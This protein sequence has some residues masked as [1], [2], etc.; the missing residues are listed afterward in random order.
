MSQRVPNCPKRL[1]CASSAQARKNTCKPSRNGVSPNSLSPVRRRARS[2][3][4]SACD[5]GLRYLDLPAYALGAAAARLT[6]CTSRRPRATRPQSAL[7][8]LP[9]GGSEAV[10][11]AGSN[12]WADKMRDVAAERP[13]LLDET[14]RDELVAV[15]R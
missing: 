5:G 12:T 1:S 9:P 14:R 10:E 7:A 13:D 8:S 2:I 4:A 6:V 11:Q 15:A 3:R